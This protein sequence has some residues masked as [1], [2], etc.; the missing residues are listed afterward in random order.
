M[1]P[2]HILAYTTTVLSRP[3]RCTKNSGRTTV[4]SRATLRQ[5]KRR[6]ISLLAKSTNTPSSAF[7]ESISTS[8]STG[9]Q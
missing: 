1:A 7:T 8:V 3:S 4:S 2:R 9:F 6:R 5:S